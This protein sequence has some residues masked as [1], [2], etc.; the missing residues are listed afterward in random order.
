MP[1][2]YL[3]NVPLVVRFQGLGQP[4]G[5]RAVTPR[6]RWTKRRVQ[7]NKSSLSGPGMA[8]CHHSHHLSHCS[9]R[10]AEI[11]QGTLASLGCCPMVKRRSSQLFLWATKRWTTKRCSCLCT[12][13]CWLEGEEDPTL[14]LL[15]PASFRSFQ[16]S[17]LPLN[18]IFYGYSSVTFQFPEQVCL[19]LLGEKKDEIQ[20]L[21][22]EMNLA[23]K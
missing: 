16:L 15:L 13:I 10:R 5:S 17:S 12:S 23:S 9:E 20:H 6:T 2:R 4:N 14:T 18:W 8:S 22:L 21:F 1:C 19:D 3:E 11:I 7:R